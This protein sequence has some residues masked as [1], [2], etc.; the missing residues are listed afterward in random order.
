MITQ[1]RTAWP[2]RLLTVAAALV[3]AAALAGSVRLVPVDPLTFHVEVDAERPFLGGELGIV[4]SS[5]DLTLLEVEPGGGF[6]AGGGL[7]AGIEQVS[8]TAVPLGGCA[9]GPGVDRGLIV[10]WIHPRDPATGGIATLPR[11]RHRV[12]RLRFAPGP[13]AAA[14]RCHPLRF[15]ACLGPAEAPIANV[16]TDPDGRSLPLAGE[17]VT[18]CAGSCRLI[19]FA[20]GDTAQCDALAIDLREADGTTSFARREVPARGLTGFDLALEVFRAFEREPAAGLIAGLLPSGVQLCRA[21]GSSLRI[22]L[23]DRELRGGESIAP[24]GVDVRGDVPGCPDRDRDGICDADDACPDLYNPAAPCPTPGFCRQVKLDP[25]CAFRCDFIS[26]ELREEDGM[27][28]IAGG[29][30][31]VTLA[32]SGRGLDVAIELCRAFGGSPP[33]GF[34][35]QRVISGCELCRSDGRR[36]RIFLRHREGGLERVQEVTTGGI[37]AACGLRLWAQPRRCEDEGDADADGDGDGVCDRIDNCSLTA[38]PAQADLLVAPG[39]LCSQSPLAVLEPD[40]DVSL[41]FRLD[42]CRRAACFA[43]EAPAGRPVALA[44]AG[45]HPANVHRLRVR[46]GGEVSPSL[47]DQAARG[48]GGQPLRLA[49]PA[50]AA[51][52]YFVRADLESAAASPSELVLTLRSVDLSLAEISPSSGAHGSRAGVIIL[53]GGFETAPERTRFSLVPV[54][55]G[56]SIPASDGAT[57]ILSPGRAE[58]VFDLSRAP[59]LA[60]GATALYHL[61]ASEGAASVRLENAFAVRDPQSAFGLEV[62]LTG[63]SFYRR[64]VL[65]RAT[66]KVHNHAAGEIIAPLF[67]ITAPAH[68][69]LRL[70][71]EPEREGSE[72]LVLGAPAE[73]FAGRLAPGGGTEVPVLLESTCPGICPATLKVELLTPLPGD[74]I[75]WGSFAAPPG[76][77]RA[78]WEAAQQALPDVLGRTWSEAHAALAAIATRLTR[79]GLDGSSVREQF[80]FA[81]RQA[82]GLPAAA[83]TGRLLEAGSRR[84]IAGA[85]VVA[86]E[87]GSV[88]SHGLTDARGSFAID[89]LE[90]GK[91]YRFEAADHLGGRE[92]TVPPEDDLH[93]LELLV[94]PG[95]NPRQP[96]C[97]RCAEE[98]LPLAPPP[99]FPPREVLTEIA[100]FRTIIAGAEDPNEKSGPQGEGDEGFVGGGE[101]LIYVIYFENKPTASFPAQRVLIIDRLDPRLDWG[102]VR[103]LDVSVGGRLF[104][105]H[106][107]G[108]DRQRGYLRASSGADPYHAVESGLSPVACRGT[109]FRVNAQVNPVTG[110]IT[111]FFETIDCN[112]NPVDPSVCPN[113]GFLPPNRE[114]P[115]GEGF[116]SFEA[117]FVSDLPDDSPVSNRADILF[118]D[119]AAIIT[120]SVRN[121]F[122]FFLPAEEPAGPNPPVYDPELDRCALP[123]L[124]LSWAPTRAYRYDLYF[125]LPEEGEPFVVRDLRAPRATLPFAL[126]HGASYRW[127]VV[128]RNVRQVE[129][130]GPVWS[131]CTTSPPPATCPP[132][133]RGLRGENADC[134]SAGAVILRW[135]AVEGAQAYDLRWRRGEEWEGQTSPGPRPELVLPEWLEPGIYEWQVLAVNEV[136]RVADWSRAAETGSFRVCGAGVRFVRGDADQSGVI[137][138]TDAVRILSFLFTGGAAPACRDAADADDSG[139]LAITDAIRILGWLFTGGHPPPAPS[140]RTG[141]YSPSDCG[142]DPTADLLDCGRPSAKCS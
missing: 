110:V 87:G 22:F 53:G 84:P 16:L 127:Q 15:A 109:D 139:S 20:P 40:R 120:N 96:A 31:T 121:V 72:L 44:L 35:V 78:D 129:T 130:P 122:S 47:F 10:S 70:L 65:S 93:D 29:T 25:L 49:V 86:L 6:P 46:A 67:R 13:D 133:P 61:E 52:R 135:N 105:L 36:F 83:V 24:C 131:F 136:C 103:L 68:T 17:E 98:R 141:N 4:F 114:A 54:G 39:D 59:A 5:R 8:A 142:L 99:L 45:G 57:A 2:R 119:E 115:A 3:P 11:G 62:R 102:S 128:A 97:P 50:A 12:L 118:D 64:R 90:Q 137:D 27:T 1:N 56:T 100:L 42:G 79:R 41:P 51:V 48:P 111:W 74:F 66:L 113:C 104:P 7:P 32:G 81:V 58:V 92:E 126:E 82:L 88:V 30:R 21:D 77:S 14:G 55:G 89:W 75:A 38:N 34:T 37:T 43:F 69:R 19:R 134:E 117:A 71:R 123:S 26:F 23:G 95:A 85:T 107:R 138:I 80:R 125:W 9:A 124:Q 76:M 112:G 94:T 63:Q 108:D 132:A 106:Y 140:P 101:P 28:P 60:E 91:R 116:V 33:P 73:G 18:V